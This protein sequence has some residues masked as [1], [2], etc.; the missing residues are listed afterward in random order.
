[1]TTGDI[2][3]WIYQLGFTAQVINDKMYVITEENSAIIYALDLTT[4]V[5]A[6]LT[7]SGIQPS[8][9]VRINSWIHNGKMYNFDDNCKLFAYNIHTN[10]W[11][12]PTQQGESPL[13]SEHNHFS[14]VKN[15]D[16]VFVFGGCKEDDSDP[17]N[18]LFLLDMGTMR[19]MKV[20]GNL[21]STVAPSSDAVSWRTL[22]RISHSETILLGIS[23][24]TSTPTCWIL[25]MKNAKQLLDPPSIWTR[26]LLGLEK[27]FHYA[28]VLEPQ[29]Q[30]L[31]IIGGIVAP[32]K[33]SCVQS[34]H[35]TDVLKISMRVPT[36]QNIATDKAARFTCT[37]DTR[38][39]Q[40]NFPDNLI[41]AVLVCKREIIGCEAMCTKA[42]G[43]K[44]CYNRRSRI[45]K[46]RRERSNVL[47]PS[48][49]YGMLCKIYKV[50]ENYE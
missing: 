2:P 38:L 50:G 6:I 45:I 36:L 18:S 44:E 48:Q 46:K 32:P 10:S 13:P 23:E 24:R 1:M 17:C 49:N 21:P 40:G 20:H 28:P 41:K 11:E 5:W 29:S 25:N 8:L 47:S 42:K 22:T 12:W 31:W 26:V 34:V 14:T 43:C 30:E 9:D 15:L 4:F 39:M 3:G 19:W 7:P 35:V 16:T 33:I 37:Q 27:R